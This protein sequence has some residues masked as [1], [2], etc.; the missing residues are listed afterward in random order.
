M[1]ILIG[2]KFKIIKIDNVERVNTLLKPNRLVNHDR[3]AHAFVYKISGEVKYHFDNTTL[4]FTPGC[5][6][7]FPK[8]SNFTIENIVL[9]ECIAINFQTLDDLNISPFNFKAKHGHQINSMFEKLEILWAKR[10]YDFSYDI[11]SEVYKI[12]EIIKSSMQSDYCAN[13]VRRNIQNIQKYIQ[14]NYSDPKISINDTCKTFQTSVSSARENFND[15]YG[16]SPKR[17]LINVRINAA[18]Q[19]L[20]ESS[21]P[22]AEIAEKVGFCDAFYFSRCFSKVCGCSPSEYRKIHISLQF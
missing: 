19:L 15:V 20:L 5:V 1:S 14:E 11:M 6:C 22:V 2:E 17:F 21:M 4:H 18:K 12:A 3:F 9:G 8:N 13:K 7:Y 16:V 10:Q